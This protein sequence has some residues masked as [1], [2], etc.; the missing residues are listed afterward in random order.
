MYGFFCHYTAPSALSSCRCTKK[1]S[2]SVAL[3]NYLP[4]RLAKEDEQQGDKDNKYQVHQ[5]IGK[6]VLA[7][8]SEKIT[9]LI[10]AEG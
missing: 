6:N 1:T 7:V 2:N 10:H 8:L 9:E 5:A 4:C 3:P